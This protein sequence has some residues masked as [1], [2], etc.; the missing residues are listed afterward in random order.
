MYKILFLL[1]ISLL[2]PISLCAVTITFSDFA[3][4]NAATGGSASLVEDFE[5]IPNGA[6]FSSFSQNG[7]TYQALSANLAIGRFRTDVNPSNIVVADGNENYQLSF[8]SG[9]TAVGFN[10]IMNSLGPATVQVFGNSG[11][12]GSFLHNHAS[13]QQGFFGVTAS[14]DITSVIWTS[15]GGGSVDEGIDNVFLGTSTIPEPTTPVMALLAITLLYV[16]KSNK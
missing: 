8:Q 5:S 12:L 2:M 10:T 14:E 6:R 3:S 15:N 4:F 9:V 16:R 1:I 13:T 7:I 11:S